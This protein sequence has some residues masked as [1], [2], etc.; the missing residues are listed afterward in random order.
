MKK[1]L[2]AYKEGKISIK[3]VLEKIEKMPYEDL[4]FAKIDNHRIIRKGFPETVYCKGKTI[5][6][7]LK[8]LRS[9]SNDYQ[10][11]LATKANKRVYNAV[12][13]DFSNAE[14]NEEAKT[15]VIENVE[16][17]QKKGKITIRKK[18]GKTNFL[19]S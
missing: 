6:Q 1:M 4:G 8:I 19:I 18:P 7:I 9:M 14:Y 5:S 2:E 12:K 15:I 17:K 16:I 11:I 10:N 13:K 3:T